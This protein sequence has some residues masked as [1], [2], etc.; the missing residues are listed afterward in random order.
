M[1]PSVTPTT[2]TSTTSYLRQDVSTLD[3]RAQLCELG[4]VLRNEQL[5]VSDGVSRLP[6]LLAVVE[7]VRRQ[8]L[9]LSGD[10][11]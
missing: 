4:E 9:F 1:S 2:T 11:M 5:V 3:V 8:R 7:A 10:V 6:K